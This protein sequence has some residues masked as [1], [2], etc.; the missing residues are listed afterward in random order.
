MLSK[1]TIYYALIALAALVSLYFWT[2]A[3][4][5]LFANH[6]L[7]RTAAARVI[8][9]EVEEISSDQFA[10]KACYSFEIDGRVYH[11]NTLLAKPYYL[12][13]PSAVAALKEKAKLSEPVTAWYRASD[14]TQS[15]LEKHFP[16]GLLL[17][18]LLASAVFIYFI[19]LTFASVKIP[20]RWKD[21]F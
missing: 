19:R 15:S 10:I 9:W 21:F 17:R 3:S 2:M 7:N 4:R 16:L 13:P 6:F 8:Q 11:G 5:I 20:T 1:K 12:N 18:A 14:P